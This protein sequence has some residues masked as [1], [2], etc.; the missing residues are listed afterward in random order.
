M[1]EYRIV[2]DNYAGYE[3]QHKTPSGV[4]QMPGY[5]A[6]TFLSLMQAKRWVR[7]ERR[8]R[9]RAARVGEVVAVCDDKGKW[10]RK[11]QL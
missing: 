9:S 4:W 10:F 7:K 11:V 1:I 8:K 6:N 3:V 2:R 5:T